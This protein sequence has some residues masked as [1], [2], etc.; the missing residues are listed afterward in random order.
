MKNLDNQKLNFVSGGEN[1]NAEPE[2]KSVKPLTKGGMA[3]VWK[4]NCPKCNKLMIGGNGVKRVDGTSYSHPY[5]CEECA[6]ALICSKN[7]SVISSTENKI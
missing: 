6:N 2:Q 3:G 7:N 5:F 4:V 1:Q